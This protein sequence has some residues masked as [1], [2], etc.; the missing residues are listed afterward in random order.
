MIELKVL[1]TEN[2]HLSRPV[3]PFAAGTKAADIPACDDTCRHRCPECRFGLGSHLTCDPH[4][5]HH[6]PAGR[7]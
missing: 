7:Q 3:D 1:R 6:H 5:D 4:C 2:K